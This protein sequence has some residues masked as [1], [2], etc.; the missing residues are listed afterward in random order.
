MLQGKIGE[1][2]KFAINLLHR[3]DDGFYESILHLEIGIGQRYHKLFFG[4]DFFYLIQNNIYFLS[5]QMKIV[6]SWMCQI[7]NVI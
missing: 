7:R 3:K 1:N 2:E 4:V 6:K 5:Q